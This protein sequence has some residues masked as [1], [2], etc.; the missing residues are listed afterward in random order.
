M[1]CA[2]LVVVLAACAPGTATVYDGD[3]DIIITAQRV[4]GECEESHQIEVSWAPPEGTTDFAL[5]WC[6]PDNFQGGW[7]PQPECWTAELGWADIGE[8]GFLHW[9]CPGH[10]PSYSWQIDYTAPQP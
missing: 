7:D 1:R 2:I 4:G 6:T 3:T 10:D 9:I 8:D 5:S